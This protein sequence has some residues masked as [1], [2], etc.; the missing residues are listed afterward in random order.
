MEVQGALEVQ[1]VQED[2]VELE[3]LEELVVEVDNI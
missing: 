1:E 3:A 2:K